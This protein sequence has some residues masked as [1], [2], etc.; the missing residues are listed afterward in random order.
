MENERMKVRETEKGWRTRTCETCDVCGRTRFIIFNAYKI[1]F[2][3]TDDSKCVWEECLRNPICLYHNETTIN[4]TTD[5]QGREKKVHK[6]CLVANKYPTK[7]IEITSINKSNDLRRTCWMSY[8]TK[9]NPLKPTVW[10]LNDQHDQNFAKKN[11]DWYF[12]HF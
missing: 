4:K 9:F 8:A 10:P 7:T 1:Y 5:H 2:F 6:L 12:I 3:H 11:S